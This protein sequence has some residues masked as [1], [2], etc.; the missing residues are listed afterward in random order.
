[1]S[2]NDTRSRSALRELRDAVQ[3]WPWG[4]IGTVPYGSGHTISGEISGSEY[5]MSS[6]S[7]HTVSGE[8]HMR[9]TDVLGEG[10][11]SD[12]GSASL[13]MLVDAACLVACCMA[14]Y[15]LVYVVGTVMAP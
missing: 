10:D 12:D 11:A 5:G 3:E 9:A 13:R 4:C 8:V 15:A 1:M 6:G 7:G 14:I 2:E